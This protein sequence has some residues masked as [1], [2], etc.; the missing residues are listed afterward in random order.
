MSFM[1]VH[2]NRPRL[3]ANSTSIAL[4]LCT[5]GFGPSCGGATPEPADQGGH[6]AVIHDA[7][8]VTPVESDDAPE[9]EA[10][11]AMGP[12]AEGS[13]STPASPEDSAPRE[14][15]IPW[16]WIER[17]LL[18][19]EEPDLDSS[20]NDYSLS[21][22]FT[23]LDGDGQEELYVAWG[24]GMANC[25]CERRAAVARRT[26]TGYQVVSTISGDLDVVNLPRGLR[27]LVHYPN[28]DD[29]YFELLFLRPGTG[30]LTT[31]FRGS[32]GSAAPAG[33]RCVG[34]GGYEYDAQVQGI[35]DFAESDGLRVLEA[36]REEAGC[37][38]GPPNT[39]IRRVEDLLRS[40]GI[41]PP[42]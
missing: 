16:R 42:E 40:A 18:A 39:T 17:E 37:D 14:D 29:E 15:P 33:T 19:A 25:R 24:V 27:G 7:G 41:L 8:T 3:W 6:S 2:G 30:R 35:L 5:A 20:P 21:V 10:E 31:F 11:G 22:A 23:D 36:I 34:E 4:V 26:T 12:A 1:L 9:S 13:S 38:E 32:Y 28:D